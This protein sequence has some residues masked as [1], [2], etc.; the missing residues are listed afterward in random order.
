MDRNENKTQRVEITYVGLANYC[1]QCEE[2][3]ED[4]CRDCAACFNG[5]SGHGLDCNVGSIEQAHIDSDN[6]ARIC[7]I[8]N[9]GECN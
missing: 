2:L 4:H 1:R 6:H 9:C 7:D 3:Y 8:E 5:D